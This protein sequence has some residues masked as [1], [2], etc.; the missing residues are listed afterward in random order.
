MSLR[1]AAFMAVI[2]LLSVLLTAC[3]AAS[4]AKPAA[5]PAPTFAKLIVTND[6]VRGA[7]NIDQS[8]P[9]EVARICSELS[10]FM[11]NERIVWRIKVMDPQTGAF[12]DDKNV[13]EV[14]VK[15]SD[16]QVVQAKYGGHGGTKD[17]PADFFWTAG[18]TVPETY[19]S[20]SLTY[21]V[22]A[23]GKDGRGAMM[24]NDFK[25]PAAFLTILDGKV[26]V[27]EKK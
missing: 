17:K 8:K 4:P 19:P 23:A 9:A 16:G 3:G 26:P 18:W 24:I 1:S 14:S 20:G 11:H 2:L 21:T 22:N 27:I 5:A 6:L 10:K 12:M 25:V 7:E 15:L 13:G